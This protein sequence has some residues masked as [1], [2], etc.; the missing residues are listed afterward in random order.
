MSVN[1]R[2]NEKLE[3]KAGVDLN[4]IAETVCAFSNTAGGK[5]LVGVS[6]SGKVI[7]VA[8]GRSTIERIVNHVYNCV[9]P[10]PIFDVKVDSIE[11]K[12]VLILTVEEGPNK[13]Y[14]FKG[15][16]IVRKG[17][18]NKVL[19]RDEI[20]NLLIEKITFDSL[21]YK[22]KVEIDSELLL[23]FIKRLKI[24]RRMKVYFNNAEKILSRLSLKNKYYRNAAILLFSPACSKIFPQAVIKVG[25]FRDNMLEDE[26][27]IEGPLIKQVEEALEYI[28]RNIEKRIKIIGLERVEEYEYPIEAI[29]EAI[30]N[31]VVHRDYRINSPSFI[32]IFEDK[33]EVFN[34]GGLPPQLTV[35]DLK[36][37][38]PSIPRNPKVARIFYLYGYMEE[39]G[40][41]TL[42]M[43]RAC[44]ERGLPDPEFKVEKGFFKVIL[45]SRKYVFRELNLTERKLY[46]YI[47]NREVVT[48]RECINFIGKSERTVHRYLK[49]L[50][51]LGLISK[52][53]KGVYKIAKD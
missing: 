38:H 5:I 15:K 33:I 11:N 53:E 29:R 30:V 4:G 12:V 52:A 35:E 31:A 13:P 18:V 41:G 19:S 36:K 9:D 42:Q 7:G 37:D 1:V 44:R 28:I 40:V 51:K 43:I 10:K 24:K 27:L 23:L 26:V 20:V 47:R 17:S 32:R 2:E 49:K 45:K 25:K 16:C 8:I 22:G 21:E 34:P 48:L 39:W 3:F 6:N 46:D 50:Q 14:F